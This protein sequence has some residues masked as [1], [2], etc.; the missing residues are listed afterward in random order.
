MTAEEIRQLR[1]RAGL[2]Q[3]DFAH[4]IGVRAR[5]IG[6]WEK[7]TSSPAPMAR[8]RLKAFAAALPPASR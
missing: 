6:R 7:G 8:K 5:E 1:R 3:E 2:T 4:A